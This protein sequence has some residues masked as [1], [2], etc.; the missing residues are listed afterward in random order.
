VVAISP[1]L[2]GDPIALHLGDGL[3]VWNPEDDDVLVCRQIRVETHDVKSFIFSTRRPRLFRYKPGQFLTLNLNIGGQPINRCYTISSAPTRPHLISITVKRVPGGP[4]SNWLHDTM[5]PGM[6]I[7]AVG[8]MGEFSTL[9]HP[10]RK[11]LFLSGGS[12]ITPLMSMSRSYHDLAGHCDIVFVHSARSPAD[13][14]F[15][16]ELELMSR[17]LPGFRMAAVCEEDTP[18]ERWTGYRGRLSLPMLQLIAPDLFEREIFI[19]GPKPYMAAVRAMLDEAGFDMARYHEESFVFEE[20]LALEH[21]LGSPAEELPVVGEAATVRFRVE[22]TKSKRVV[23]CGAGTNVLD[24]AR[25]AGLRLPSSC[26]R[27][28]CGTCKSK[29]VSG[30]VDMKHAGGIRQREIDQGQILICCSRPLGDLVIE[31]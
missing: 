27:G 7:R 24:A 3:P 20:M 12:G 11:Y 29:L 5:R 14:I 13:I 25:A 26:T 17:N 19:C 15:R 6:E 2:A 31:R 21:M 10:A 30:K 8:P 23:E 1:D 18:T 9:H 28:L 4:V 16:T 22:F